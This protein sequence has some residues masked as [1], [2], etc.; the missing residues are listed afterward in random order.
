MD[1]PELLNQPQVVYHTLI[2]TLLLHLSM[3]DID[4]RFVEFTGPAIPLP[5]GG[6]YH[7]S[8]GFTTVNGTNPH[9]HS[10]SGRTS[11]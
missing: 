9:R 6:H 11:L 2:D 8:S 5:N 3:I 10:Y 4:M 7:E 1:M